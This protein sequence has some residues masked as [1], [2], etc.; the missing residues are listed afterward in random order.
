MNTLA[1]KETMLLKR[2][3]EEKERYYGLLIDHTHKELKRGK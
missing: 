2:L 3:A 1:L